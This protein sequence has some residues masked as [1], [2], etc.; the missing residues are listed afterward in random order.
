[1]SQQPEGKAIPAEG[2]LN[3]STPA[4]PMFTYQTFPQPL[5]DASNLPSVHSQRAAAAFQQ[6][7]SQESPGQGQ[8]QPAQPSRSSSDCFSMDPAQ[9]EADIA[10]LTNAIAADAAGMDAASEDRSDCYGYE[11]TRAAA[12]AELDRHASQHH[13]GRS[14]GDH[15]PAGGQHAQQTVKLHH[16]QVD[17]QVMHDR[18]NREIMPQAG[19]LSWAQ[20][21]A[22]RH[23]Y[24]ER[25]G[26]EQP[27]DLQYR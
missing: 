24:K 21:G 8:R 1:M 7:P 19:G 11:D 16:H 23:G 22:S 18:A 15:M 9:L 17:S 12:Q 14:L 4:S 10:A 26:S 25:S 6:S 20:R 5:Q 13:P 3:N 27:H 2:S